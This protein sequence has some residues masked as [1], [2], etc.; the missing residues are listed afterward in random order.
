[1]WFIGENVIEYNVNLVASKY[2][3]LGSVETSFL[4][5][6]KPNT[7]FTITNF[8]YTDLA[9]GITLIPKESI[10]RIAN[11]NLADSVFGLSMESSNSGW[12][13]PGS[14]SFVKS[15]FLPIQ[16]QRNYEK[17]STNAVPTLLFYLHHSKNIS[18][19]QDLG[20]VRIL[21]S[22]SSSS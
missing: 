16:G 12:L 19:E 20:T 22:A 7:T 8:D 3:T 2:S 1:M 14:T 15:S 11:D 18:I 4:E 5:F 6:S 9:R 21:I 17:D 13:T 10:P